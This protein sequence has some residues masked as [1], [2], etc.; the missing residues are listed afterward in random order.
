M[1]EAEFLKAKKE[2]ARL[3]MQ[4]AVE[5]L[6]VSLPQVFKLQTWVDSYP[7]HMTGSAFVAGFLVTGRV[8]SD[9]SFLIPT[10]TS[11]AT[12]HAVSVL[13]EIMNGMIPPQFH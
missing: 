9:Q 1:N 2:Q 3:K 4:G 8:F 13:N 6:K 10:L 7:W 11:V 5:R 12:G